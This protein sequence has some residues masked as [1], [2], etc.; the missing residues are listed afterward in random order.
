MCKCHITIFLLPAEE[1]DVETAILGNLSAIFP[2]LLRQEAAV[3]RSAYFA[4]GPKPRSSFLFVRGRRPLLWMCGFIREYRRFSI[5]LL[6]KPLILFCID[7]R[8]ENTGYVRRNA[9]SNGEDS[10]GKQ[11]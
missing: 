2:P 10:N 6:Y 5:F 4:S 11:F 7:V 9:N 8:E 3:A 1:S